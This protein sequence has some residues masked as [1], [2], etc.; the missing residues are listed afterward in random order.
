MTQFPSIF[1][2]IDIYILTIMPLLGS[3]M[4]MISDLSNLILS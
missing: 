1:F 4:N 2:Q 3:D